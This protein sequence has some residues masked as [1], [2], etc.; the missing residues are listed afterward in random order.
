MSYIVNI[1]NSG[2]LWST[3]INI[4]Y[5][6]KEIGGGLV[7]SGSKCVGGGCVRGLVQF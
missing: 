3:N 1:I 5:I 2:T 7:P 4:F 6:F